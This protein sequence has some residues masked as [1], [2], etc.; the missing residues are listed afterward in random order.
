MTEIQNPLQDIIAKLTDVNIYYLLS[1][2][3]CIYG[4]LKYLIKTPKKVVK[5]SISLSV[6]IILFTV[7]YML[8]KTNIEQLIY[9]FFVAMVLYNWIIKAIMARLGDTYNNNKGV[10]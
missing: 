6:G 5:I 7:F 2:V 3:L 1:T 10:I 8:N 9:T 4:I